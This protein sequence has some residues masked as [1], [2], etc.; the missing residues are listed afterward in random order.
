MR[1]GTVQSSDPIVGR[2]SGSLS[3]SM[4]SGWSGAVAPCGAVGQWV[5]VC[6]P[7]TCQPQTVPRAQTCR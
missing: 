3:C 2:C 6:Q 4:T 7:L 5:T 1:D